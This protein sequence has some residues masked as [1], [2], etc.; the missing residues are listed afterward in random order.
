MPRERMQGRREHGRLAALGVKKR[1][2]LKPGTENSATP[3][4]ETVVSSGPASRLSL[5]AGT[6]SAR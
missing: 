5:K 3:R 1:H 2:G 4:G 6:R